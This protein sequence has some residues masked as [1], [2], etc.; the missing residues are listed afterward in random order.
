LTRPLYVV[1]LASSYRL[2]GLQPLGYH[3]VNHAFFIVA[4][5]LCCL[6]LREERWSRAVSLS[7]AAVFV[8]LPNYSTDRFWIAA[9]H[10]RLL[11]ASH[12]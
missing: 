3:L 12:S 11:R 9:C 7:V 2:F 10:G 8:F 6:T 1:L 5:V 4:A